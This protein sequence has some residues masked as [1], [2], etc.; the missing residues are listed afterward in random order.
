MWDGGSN[1]CQRHREAPWCPSGSALLPG[2]RFL[3]TR[4]RAPLFLFTPA[5]ALGGGGWPSCVCLNQ[6]DVLCSH[7]PGSC[8]PQ[9]PPCCGPGALRRP[10]PLT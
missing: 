9:P 3:A 8:A 10:R 4:S 6:G 2:P 7:T 5:Y 1:T